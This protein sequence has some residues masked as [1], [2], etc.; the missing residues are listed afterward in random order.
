MYLDLKRNWLRSLLLECPFGTPLKSCPLEEIRKLPE[1][2]GIR[3]IEALSPH[4]LEEY[5]LHHGN[6]MLEREKIHP[7]RSRN[8]RKEILKRRLDRG[9][10]FDQRF[11]R[12][13]HST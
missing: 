6:C 13:A 7:L 1:E 10:R 4:V 8:P 5:L 11:A 12:V 3:A 2:E 9:A